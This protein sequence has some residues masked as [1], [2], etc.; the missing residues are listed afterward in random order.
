[1]I[2]KNR[3]RF[4]IEV[5]E[6]LILVFALSWFVNTFVFG[7]TQVKDNGMLPAL[8]RGDQ[9]LINKSPINGF[10]A[11]EG[12]DIVVFRQAPD[13]ENRVKRLIGLA[14]DKIE[15]RN[16]FTYVNGNPIYEPY[17]NTPVTCQFQAITVPQDHVFVLNDD[18]SETNDSRTLGSIREDNLIGEAIF[19]YWPWAKI[20]SL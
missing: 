13:Q 7:L 12:G 8:E 5:L 1:M 14:G 10:G 11:L 2:F 19:C 3:S 6:I 4:I 18:R 20:K 16:G 17:A 9:V 15:I